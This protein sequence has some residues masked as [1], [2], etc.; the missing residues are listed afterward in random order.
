MIRV[1]MVWGL[2]G[3]RLVLLGW[4]RRYGTAGVGGFSVEV[5]GF[6]LYAGLLGQ[7]AWER[8]LSV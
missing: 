3:G 6:C 7:G 2:L 1:K 8:L 4:C 5:G